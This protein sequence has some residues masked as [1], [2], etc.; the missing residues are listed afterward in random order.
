[1]KQS[2]APGSGRD[3]GTDGAARGHPTSRATLRS[4]ATS[5]DPSKTVAWSLRTT[6]EV[7]VPSEVVFVGHGISA[8]GRAGTIRDVDV[9]GKT[10]V[11]LRQRSVRRPDDVLRPLDVTSSK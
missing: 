3:L 9:K 7:R 5:F 8:P 4:I 10:V 11:F 2:A 6:P 1:M